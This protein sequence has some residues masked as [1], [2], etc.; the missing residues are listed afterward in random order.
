MAHDLLHELGIDPDDPEV[1][2]AIEDARIVGVIKDALICRR[3]TLGLTPSEVEQRIGWRDGS[4]TD[5][6]RL[7]RVP[8]VSAIQQYARALGLRL[9]LTLAGDPLTA[10]RT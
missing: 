5:F 6:E 4:A 9:D 1:A 8:T 7:G 2:A 3:Q 10:R